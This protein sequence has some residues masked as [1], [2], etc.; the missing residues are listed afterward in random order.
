[1]ATRAP[2]TAAA[3]PAHAMPTAALTRG[4]ARISAAAAAFPHI[5]A[6]PSGVL[7]ACSRGEGRGAG[8]RATETPMFAPYHILSQRI[9]PR[10][11]KEEGDDGGV[12]TGSRPMQRSRAN[13]Q[14]RGRRG[15]EEGGGE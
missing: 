15:R 1:M 3:A 4:S 8:R 10:G 9:H 14:G 11:R 6:L 2:A 12:A 13:L 5:C 7:P